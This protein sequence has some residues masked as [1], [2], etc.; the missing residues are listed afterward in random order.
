MTEETQLD[1]IVYALA[2]SPAFE[3]DGICFA[4]R[5]TGLYCSQDGGHTWTDAYASLE[6]EAQL[7]TAAVILSPAFET[8]RSV[9]AGVAGGVLRSLDGGQTWYVASF[10][11]PPPFVSTLAISPDFARDGTLFA[12]TLEDGIFRSGDRGRSW[13][14]W[15]FGL[16]DLN[17]LALA[18]SPD[19]ANDETLFAGTESGIFRSTN[20]G[21]AWR[22]V[23]FPTDW[24]PVLSLALSPNFAGD[25][26]IFAGTEAHGL[27]RS[28][29]RGTTWQ[30]LAEKRLT[31]AV[32]SILLSAK[33]PA[34]ADVLVLHEDELL[35][36]RD[37]GN[38][39]ADWQA[40]VTIEGAV[41][42]VSAPQGLASGVPLLIGLMD[43]TVLR[44]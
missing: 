3:E 31:D 4:A 40:N 8:D 30:R 29:Y 27:F 15:N 39:W 14:A 19:Y 37:G 10:P 22:E 34:Q 38:S 7:T 11:S 18:A 35:I 1:E 21:R 16:L 9:F 25:G 36:S 5:P 2:A 32:N 12:A 44:G 33:Y 20:G 17:V 13:A 26:L 41:A 28:E 6:L 24:A 42:S 43:G 23:D